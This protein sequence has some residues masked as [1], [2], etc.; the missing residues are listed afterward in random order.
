MIAD[1]VHEFERQLDEEL[2]AAGRTG[3]SVRVVAIAKKQ[4]AEAVAEVISAGI[5]DIGENYVQEARAK[6]ERLPPVR[7]HFVGHIQT[8]KAR[9]IVD[10]FDLV[11][12]VDSLKAGVALSSAAQRLS[13][14][15]AVLV[16]V[17]ISPTERYGVAPI[18]AERL[19]A[20]LRS[21]DGIDVEGVMA[22]GPL[23]SDRAEILR[24]FE[25]AAKTF[26]RVGGSTLSMGMTGDWREAIR[27]G[28]TML[29]IGTALFGPRAG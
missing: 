5:R 8:N 1:R 20:E 2:R 11:Q 12:S 3:D 6:F 23:D 7:K 27:A 26:A 29:R 14:R 22:I 19:A 18:L 13:K 4:P 16:Q 17:N 15:V 28:T 25:V 10:T 9:A 21:L 24:S